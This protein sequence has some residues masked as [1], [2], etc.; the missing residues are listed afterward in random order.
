MIRDGHYFFF[1]HFAFALCSPKKFQTAIA[2][3]SCQKRHLQ[4]SNCKREFSVFG[5]QAA[6]Y[7][8]QNLNLK[9]VGIYRPNSK[10]K[11]KII[12]SPLSNPRLKLKIDFVLPVGLLVPPIRNPVRFE[13]LETST[14][15]CVMGYPTSS[16]P[17]MI[18]PE[19]IEY[20]YFRK[21]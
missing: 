16:R 14:F 15:G 9:I 2:I 11:S 20:R 8:V 7:K 18:L 3:G 17:Q 4:T 13:P 12:N 19:Y 1:L 10:H 6:N 5:L 21:Y